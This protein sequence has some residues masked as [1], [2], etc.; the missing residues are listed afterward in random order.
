MFLIVPEPQTFV[1]GPIY[2]LMIPYLF[3]I[4]PRTAPCTDSRLPSFLDKMPRGKA[5]E[6]TRYENNV[7]IQCIKAVEPIC[8]GEWK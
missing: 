8:M 4:F 1:R 3:I 2:T 5:Q 6:V 7:L